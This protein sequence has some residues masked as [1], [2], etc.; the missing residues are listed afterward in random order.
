MKLNS[1]IIIKLLVF[2]WI[3]F[4]FLKNDILFC[5]CSGNKLA[6]KHEGKKYYF[7]QKDIDDRGSIITLAARNN[8]AQPSKYI[9]T[10]KARY[11]SENH[12]SFH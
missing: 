3:D 1:D 8:I 7:V 4:Y 12:E 2:E 6:I 9:K 11:Y 5:S 10:P